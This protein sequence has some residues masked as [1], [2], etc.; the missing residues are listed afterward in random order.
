MLKTTRNLTHRDFRQR[1]KRVDSHFY[2]TG[3]CVNI[4]ARKSRP[5]GA[6]LLGFGWAYLIVALS[7]NRPAIESSLKQGTLPGEY[8]DWIMAGLAAV[9]AASMI[10]FAM[11]L[12]RFLFQSGSRRTNSG[13][14]LV[15]TCAALALI[16]TPPDVWK[17][18]FHMLDEN[19]RSFIINASDSME[20]EMPAVD[21]TEVAF[22]SSRS[23]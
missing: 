11:H 13:G 5:I 20:I 18:G 16:Y 15:G 9:I 7:S 22:V 8:H 3:N 12:I 21:F 2:R 23:E 6:T 14:I 4:D 17:A 10:M 19:A 1:I